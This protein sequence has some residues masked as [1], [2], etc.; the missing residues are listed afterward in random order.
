MN[1][2][3]LKFISYLNKPLADSIKP[4][5]HATYPSITAGLHDHFFYDPSQMGWNTWHR[6]GAGAGDRLFYIGKSVEYTRILKR[7]LSQQNGGWNGGHY[8]WYFPVP[9][10]L[11]WL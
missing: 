4:N 8:L 3:L 1:L 2:R 7:L 10:R 5:H 9:A 6:T 11:S